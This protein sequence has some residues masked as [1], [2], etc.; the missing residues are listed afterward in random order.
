[1]SEPLESLDELTS[2]NLREG[3]TDDV[4]E[5]IQEGLSYVPPIDDPLDFDDAD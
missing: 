1:L 2:E 5:A 4:I 3:E